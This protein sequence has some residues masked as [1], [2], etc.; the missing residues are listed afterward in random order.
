MAKSTIASLEARIIA[1]ETELAVLR[2][3]SPAPRRGPWQPSSQLQA[4]KQE[5]LR[6][7]AAGEAVVIRGG[8]CVLQNEP[9]LLTA[10][11]WAAAL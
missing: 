10:S 6:R 4:A 8:K 5:F 2:T 3:Q 9:P 7:K 11:E 1:L